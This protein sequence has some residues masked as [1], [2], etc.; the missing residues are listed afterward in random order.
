MG[1]RRGGKKSTKKEE[2]GKRKQ[3]WTGG[4]GNRRTAEKMVGATNT[5]QGE[6]MNGIN[7]GCEGE[8]N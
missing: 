6:H 4:E 8:I 7:A 1:K 2:Q 3:Q 5:P